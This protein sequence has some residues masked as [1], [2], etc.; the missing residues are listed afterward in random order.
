M[1]IACPNCA[2]SYEVE[3][4]SLGAGR[5]VRCA[6]CRTQWFA[7][8]EVPESAIAGDMA[9]ADLPETAGTGTFEPDE[10]TPDGEAALLP[11]DR[12]EPPLDSGDLVAE[13][14]G[15]G[16]V[17][18]DMPAIEH[19]PSIVPSA[20]GPVSPVVDETAFPMTGGDIEAF[21]ARQRR[22][23]QQKEKKLFR[24]SSLRWPLPGLP[25]LVLALIA[26]GTVILGWRTE[27][28]RLLPQTASLYAY[29]GLGVNL[30]GVVFENIK[31]AREM[32]EGIPVMIVEGEIVSA[33][34]KPAEIPRLRFGVRNE[35]GQ[36]IYNWTAVATR[37][38]VNPG[39]RVPFRSRLASPPAEAR[40]VVVRFF[41]RRDALGGL[42]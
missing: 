25:T 22:I 21:T 40:D 17:V 30:R 31:T 19:A 24:L 3:A 26:A 38:I 18:A 15:D 20:D 1:L 37:S 8:A 6:R 35:A 10:L 34:K 36:E 42:R 4:A 33:S 16:Q 28:V 5:T 32:H 13:P 11:D 12:A 2:T 23:R 9:G 27:V 14:A 39:E 29:M 7:A 41:S